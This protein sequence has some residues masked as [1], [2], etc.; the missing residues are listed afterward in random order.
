VRERSTIWPWHESTKE[1][2]NFEERQN[3]LS[4]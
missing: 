4:P 3:V 2:D 1:E